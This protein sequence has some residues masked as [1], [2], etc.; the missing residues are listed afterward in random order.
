MYFQNQ[1]E[2]VTILLSCSGKELYNL[3]KI[4]LPVHWKWICSRTGEN[5]LYGYHTDI[6]KKLQMLSVLCYN[7]GEYSKS[8]RSSNGVTTQMYIIERNMKSC[9]KSIH[10]RVPH[11]TGAT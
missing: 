9:L 5:I 3:R 7:I 6:M 11:S 8:I 1:V 4:V 10:N 2:N